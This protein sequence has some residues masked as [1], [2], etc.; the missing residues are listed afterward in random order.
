MSVKLSLWITITLYVFACQTMNAIKPKLNEFC[1]RS[2]IN[3]IRCSIEIMENLLNH[4]DEA[5]FTGAY[6]KRGPEPLW[7]ALINRFIKVE[8]TIKDP[9]LYSDKICT[10]VRQ[11]F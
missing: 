8:T 3:K 1:S 10:F 5:G 11:I 4:C 7:I 2:Q 9:K 6:S